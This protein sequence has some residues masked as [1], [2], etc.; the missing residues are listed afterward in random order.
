MHSGAG[1]GWRRHIGALCQV[2]VEIILEDDQAA[3]DLVSPQLSVL[4]R[5]L[6]R[7]FRSAAS[8]RDVCFCEWLAHGCVGQGP[9][10][11][12]CQPEKFHDVDRAQANRGLSASDSRF[13]RP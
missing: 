13:C 1:R 7:F 5:A 8:N 9:L 3:A 2:N 10:N 11:H 12:S 4:D 6:Y